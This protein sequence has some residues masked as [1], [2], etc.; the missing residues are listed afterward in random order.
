MQS[1]TI[2]PQGEPATARGTHPLEPLFHPRT[3]AV[4]GASPDGNAGFDFVRKIQA[5]GFKGRIYPVNPRAAPLLGLTAYP[6]ISAIPD[7]VDFVIFATPA[8]VVPAAMEECVAKGVKLAHLF[9]A[10]LSETG[11]PELAA[12]ERRIVEIARRG[13]VRILGSNGMGLYYPKEGISFRANYPKE[14]GDIGFIS[15]SGGNAW[16]FVYRA[17]LRGLRF[18]KVISYGNACDLNEADYLEYLA[19]DPET[20][21]IT[22]YIEG[23]RGGQRFVEALKLAAQVK[24]V[25]ILKGGRTRAGARATASHT[26]SLAGDHLVWEGLLRQAGALGAES[27]EEL[28]DLTVALRFFPK[29]GGRRAAALGGGGGGSVAAADACDEAGFLLP[30]LPGDI[31]EELK[32]LIPATWMMISNP[33]DNS[34]IGNPRAAARLQELAFRHEAFDFVLL[35]LGVDSGLEE[36]QGVERMRQSVGW[37][38]ELQRESGRPTAFIVRSGDAREEWRRESVNRERERLVQAGMPVFPDIRRATRALSRVLR[39][40]EERAGGMPS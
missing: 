27:L 2:P 37:L 12:L 31:V 32:Q 15:Q 29:P 30:R 8:A 6:S 38:I 40:W 24:P 25:V 4:V 10:R 7:E 18:S 34:A 22:A 17:A 33:I 36:E 3:I 5:A 16:E 19:Q 11:V 13:G 28:A 35:E 39:Y 21:V 14:P 23:V 26:A 1:Q 20:R 9:T